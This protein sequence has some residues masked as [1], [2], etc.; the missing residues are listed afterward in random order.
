MP[1]F[2]TEGYL[3]PLK[4]A[5]M[6]YNMIFFDCETWV[7]DKDTHQELPMRYGYGIYH[8]I[9]KKVET[10]K[11]LTFEFKN[12]RQFMSH[13]KMFLNKKF[14]LY[15]F[16]HNVGFDIRV[17]GL[18]RFFEKLG[19]ESEPPIINEK[20]FLWK[21]KTPKGTIQF[22]D[23]ANIGVRSV[24]QIGEILDY[25]K[26]EIDFNT[27]NERLLRKYCIRDVEIIEKYTLNHLK[28]LYDN[29][30]GG[31]R[32][33]LASQALA[34]FR[35]KFMSN[36]PYIHNHLDTI[37]LER[38]AY[39]GGRTECFHIGKPPG[40]KFYYL[41]INSMYPYVMMNDKLPVRLV[42]YYENV[43]INWL[44]HRK[45]RF[46]HIIR[47]EVD[48]DEP[49]Y[50]IKRE[51]KLVFPT[52][53]FEVV[54]HDCEILHALD[55]GHIK[56]I[57]NLAQYEFGPVFKDYIEFF[58]PLK[59]QYSIEN[60]KPY[61]DIVKLFLNALYGKFGQLQVVRTVDEESPY[62]EIFRETG[63]CEPDDYFF[64]R[65][66]WYGQV[67]LEYKKGETP[68]SNCAIAGA[69]TA[70]ARLLLWSYIRKAGRANCFYCDTDS[71]FVN[72][73]GFSNLVDTIDDNE[74]GA[75]AI[76]DESEHLHIYAPKDYEFGKKVKIKGI[77]DKSKYIG[78]NRWEVLQF[79]GFISWLNKG[80]KTTPITWNIEKSRQSEYNKGIVNKNG[81]VVPFEL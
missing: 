28:F 51:G 12:A 6:P 38:D 52:G 35:Y 64:S 37:E 20:M 21:V 14:V 16:A 66:G 77:N 24:K 45:D 78:E 54:L 60:N 29:K 26:G 43:D 74:L 2:R 30:L 25:P 58:Y 19:F 69:I 31:F 72:H 49:I 53:K 36:P 42:G 67:F 17:L 63:Y 33:T 70:Y 34:I 57:Y 76:E 7:V 41:D 39:H 5:I 18:P 56:Y 65:I 75:L 11:R 47:C 13:I 71:L 79:E 23:T 40:D 10:K 48:T 15:V 50:A 27:K 80:A 46:Y 73:R 8:N 22:I 59:K 68:H 62:A 55:R 61:R 32:S 44:N 1:K 4:T 9:N 81:T 3:K